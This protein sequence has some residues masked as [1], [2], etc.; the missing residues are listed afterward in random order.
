MLLSIVYLPTNYQPSRTPRGNCYSLATAAS[1]SVTRTGVE[2]NSR[3]NSKLM[4][5]FLPAQPPIAPCQRALYVFD[6]SNFLALFDF[7]PL[8]LLLFALQPGATCRKRNSIFLWKIWYFISLYPFLCYICHKLLSTS[9]WKKI[10]N[11]RDIIRVRIIHSANGWFNQF[12]YLI[13][14]FRRRI[15]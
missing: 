6:R 4:H 12:I 9:C 8:N 2:G 11:T 3:G 1:V 13:L 15:I 7:P 10:G 14:F 5:H